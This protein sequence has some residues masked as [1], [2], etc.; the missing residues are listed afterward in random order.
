MN[1]SDFIS[2]TA[3][4]IA[5]RTNLMCVTSIESVFA[6]FLVDRDSERKILSDQKQQPEKNERK[7]KNP[8]TSNF[9]HKFNSNDCWAFET[10]RSIASNWPWNVA[11]VKKQHTQMRVSQWRITM[12]MNKRAI[13]RDLSTTFIVCLS[14]FLYRSATTCIHSN[15]KNDNK[16]RTRHCSRTITHRS[17]PIQDVRDCWTSHRS[18]VSPF[19]SEFQLKC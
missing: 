12:C 4:E 5:L 15:N 2:W 3:T 13:A 10:S 6:T 16:Q 14:L 7:K 9:Q 1:S 11:E 17:I 8:I 18:A 19:G